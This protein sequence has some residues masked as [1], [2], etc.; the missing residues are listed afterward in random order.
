MNF[1]FLHIALFLAAFF[2]ALPN[3]CFAWPATVISVH[4]GDTL[5]VAPLGDTSTPMIIRLYGIDAPELEQS[6][7]KEA[8]D[9]LRE[10]LPP[11][12]AVEIITMST[13]RYGRTVGLVGHNGKIMNAAMIAAGHAWVFPKYCRA[14]FCKKW[15]RMEDNARSSGNGLWKSDNFV[16]PWEFR[17]NKEGN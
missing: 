14:K 9:Y 15:R 3:A 16:S 17:K 12:S 1:R 8:G 13:D 7:G 5:T 11:E 6:G 2:L 4:D 10:S